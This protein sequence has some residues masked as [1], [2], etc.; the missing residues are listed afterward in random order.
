MDEPSKE[1]FRQK[2]SDDYL[3]MLNENIAKKDLTE[4]MWMAYCHGWE[5]AKSNPVNA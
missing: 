2:F 4:L 5:V 3:R 1:A